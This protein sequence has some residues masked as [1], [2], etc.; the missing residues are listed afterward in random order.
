MFFLLAACSALP[1]PRVHRIPAACGLGKGRSNRN[2]QVGLGGARSCCA[3]GAGAHEACRCSHG[4]AQ[5]EG[6]VHLGMPWVCARVR[7]RREWARACTRRPWLPPPPGSV[8]AVPTGRAASGITAR[9]GDELFPCAGRQ[10][11][12]GPRTWCGDTWSLCPS[13]R[14]WG[15]MEL[16]PAAGAAGAGSSTSRLPR[17]GRGRRF[18]AVSPGT[19]DVGKRGLEKGGFAVLQP[20]SPCRAPGIARWQ[21]KGFSCRAV[22]SCSRQSTAPGCR[23]AVWSLIAAGAT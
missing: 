9:P 21:S 6:Q 23:G 15:R 13:A 3:R 11:R 20:F 16:E 7:R 2:V 5:L 17:W 14:G 19:A 10:G 18:A 8:G 1:G 22:P 4:R 12:V